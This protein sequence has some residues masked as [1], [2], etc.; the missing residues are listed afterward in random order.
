ML[1]HQKIAIDECCDEGRGVREIV[2]G[3]LA[4]KLAML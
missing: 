3:R 4:T 1:V 2:I